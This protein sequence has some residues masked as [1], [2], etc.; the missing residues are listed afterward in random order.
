MKEEIRVVFGFTK[1]VKII[2]LLI[3]IIFLCL[4]VQ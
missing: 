1:V 2:K 3:K 4:I